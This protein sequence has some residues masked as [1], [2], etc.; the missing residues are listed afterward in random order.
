MSMLKRSKALY[1]IILVI[2]VIVSFI[3][4]GMINKEDKYNFSHDCS[5]SDELPKEKFYGE[6]F[7]S[8]NEKTNQEVFLDIREIEE[9]SHGTLYSLELS[10]DSLNGLQEIIPKEM[11]YLGYFYVTENEVFFKPFEEI[12]E[13]VDEYDISIISQ[14]E[15]NGCDFLEEWYNISTTQ[16]T[17]KN[18]ENYEEILRVEIAGNKCFFYDQVYQKNNENKED[19]LIVWEKGRGLLYYFYQTNAMEMYLMRYKLDHEKTPP[20]KLD[21]SDYKEYL[22]KVWIPE[23]WEDISIGGFCENTISFC[24][25][26]M[27]DGEMEGRMLYKSIVDPPYD[28][29]S[30]NFTG[31]FSNGV[32]SCQFENQDDEIYG[33]GSYGEFTIAFNDQN[34]LEVEFEYVRIDVG[35][36]LFDREVIFETGHATE[37]CRAYNISDVDKLSI[38]SS[39]KVKTDILGEATL[40]MGKISFER[41]LGVLYLTNESGDI[42]YDFG[43][44]KTGTCGIFTEMNEID[45]NKDEITDMVF[46]EDNR[47]IGNRVHIFL[48]QKD[49]Q[50]RY[51]NAN[52][53]NDSL[54]YSGVNSNDENGLTV[55]QQIAN[56]EYIYHYLE[57]KGWSLYAICSLLGNV[58]VESHL[59]PA[60]INN[61]GETNKYGILQWD[62]T[63]EELLNW[64]DE[65]NIVIENKYQITAKELMDLQ[66]LYCIYTAEPGSGENDGFWNALG[67]NGE[68]MSFEEYIQYPYADMEG[69]TSIFQENYL[70]STDRED[71]RKMWSERWFRHFND[72]ENILYYYDEF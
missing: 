2:G 63:E 11:K 47:Y 23:N 65:N 13:N 16:C 20:I 30:K 42:I 21:E 70:H 50:Y 37:I 35:G 14:A 24:I 56:G 17:R 71:E 43:G 1:I 69:L 31:N 15:T 32:W 66:L 41:Y 22:Y 27:D 8:E 18:T 57:E 68:Y 3:L 49:G 19:Y 64:A 72:N 28:F 12:G 33:D 40:V 52:F 34:K 45:I 60:F 61:N 46:V 25:T 59:N 10:Q 58:T 44:Y 4:I 36:N 7:S 9:F 5:P 51:A 29:D 54:V 48:Q 67:S 55:E 6:F 38:L 53:N 62:M 26:K 39:S